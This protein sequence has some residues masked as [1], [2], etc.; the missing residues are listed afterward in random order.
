MERDII[1]YLLDQ[2]NEP[3][4]IAD[5]KKIL[6]ANTAFLELINNADIVGKEITVLFKDGNFLIEMQEERI[7]LEGEMLQDI[8][9]TE[10]IFT[11]KK[12]TIKNVNQAHYIITL[13]RGIHNRISAE[14]ADFADH[15]PVMLVQIDQNGKILFA[16][17]T[18]EE[19]LSIHADLSGDRL[20][21]FIIAEDQQRFLQFLSHNEETFDDFP[22]L[23][24]V[25]K[26]G[27]TLWMGFS[28]N[29]K[30]VDQSG[31]HIISLILMNSKIIQKEETERQKDE[32][33][34][35]NEEILAQNLE[36]E[37]SLSKNEVLVKKLMESE[38]KYR[39]LFENMMNGFALQEIITD[40]KGKPVNFRY[41]DAN[42]AFER[43][44]TMPVP[45]IIGKTIKEVL[46]DVEE[47]WI[48]VYGKVG[49]TQKPIRYENFAAA[50]N[51]YFDVWA[52]SPSKGQCAIIFNDITE[53]KNREQALLQS[54]RTYK[55]I[56]ELISD[57]IYQGEVRSDRKYKVHWIMGAV[58]NI[59]GYSIE[60]LKDHELGFSRIVHPDDLEY[61]LHNYH[62]KMLQLEEVVMEYR[63]RHKDGSQRWLLDKVK[64]IQD[65]HNTDVI[66]LFGAVTDIT[67][68]KNARTDLQNIAREYKQLIET[69]PYGIN[70]TDRNGNIIIANKG[71]SEITGYAH[72]EVI[73]KNIFDFQHAKDDKTDYKKFLKDLSVSQPKPEPFF[74]KIK[75]K[76]GSLIDVQIDWDYKKD[77]NKNIVGFVN[78]LSDI[79]ERIKAE[80][81]IQ[82][83][84]QKYKR[85]V[86]NTNALI[87]EI[88]RQGNYT[89]VNPRHE[90]LLGFS[91]EELIGKPALF[92]FHPDEKETAR[93]VYK[94]VWE[95][96]EMHTHFWKLRDKNNVYKIFE[97]KAAPY[98]D[99]KG[100]QKMVVIAYEVTERVH[101]EKQLKEMADRFKTLFY[102][103]PIGAI[104]FDIMGNVVEVNQEL[105]DILGSPSIEQTKKINV[106][107]FPLLQKFGISD[108]FVKCVN[109]GK[110]IIEKKKYVSKWG[111]ESLLRYHL[112]PI[113]DEENAVV[114]IQALV[115]DFTELDNKEKELSKREK[116]YRMLVNEMQEGLLV[117]DNDDRILFV[118]KSFCNML[119]YTEKELLGKISYK[120]LLD[121][122]DHNL[123]L[124][125]NKMRNQHKA[126]QYELTM[127]S[128]SGKPILMFLNASAI[129]N[130]KD[131]VTGSMATCVDITKI[132]EQQKALEES[133]KKY[134]NIFEN[135]KIGIF[136]SHSDGALLNLNNK[137]MEILG[138]K[139]RKESL[140]FFSDMTKLYADETKR[141]ELIQQLR[142]EGNVENFEFLARKKTGESIWISINASISQ[143]DSEQ[144][145]ILDGFAEDITHKK[146]IIE[147]QKETEIAKRS[148][149]IKEQ[150]LAN[151]SHEIRTPLTGITGMIDFLYQTELTQKQNEYLGLIKE[152]SDILINLINDILDISKIEAG[153][154]IMYDKVFNLKASLSGVK[155]MFAMRVAQKDLYL[156]M[157][158]DEKLPEWIKLDENRLKQVLINLLSNAIKFTHKGGIEIIVDLAEQLS[159]EKIKIKISVK[160]SGIGISDKD[161]ALLFQKFSQVD[162]SLTRNF[163]GSGLGLSICKELV[164]LM[165]GTIGVNSEIGSGST[166]WFSFIT[167]KIIDDPEKKQQ[168]KKIFEARKLNYEILLVE[169][170]LVN[171]KVIKMMLM[172]MGCK[173]DIALN[174]Q[175][176]LDQ[177]EIKSYDLILMDIMMP[178]MD[179]MT[180]TTKIKQKKEITAPVVGLSANAM[181]G[182]AEKYIK[183]GM[184][185]YLVKP[186][187]FEKLYEMIAKWLLGDE[188]N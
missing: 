72:E 84:Q 109:Q 14:F 122:K 24:L 19:M 118:N 101:A 80:Q 139:S 74:G 119:G 106:L 96:G 85:I 186:V 93:Q 23:R 104:I 184:D 61:I 87:C 47:K 64:P 52:F 108:D 16:T 129:S 65:P 126:E 91:Q 4:I 154:M 69:I 56:S 134:R 148:A 152:S 41:L 172:N 90:E 164:R 115:E 75:H 77:E 33:Q 111:K 68:E 162:T 123:I 183:A 50:L 105:A 88:D 171:Q 168:R 3:T 103:A 173:V 6:S 150:F 131:E 120:L 82:L 132:R 102:N 32:I 63:I 1:S 44:T 53:R 78:V 36:L 62:Y 8:L 114:M 179:G 18:L 159:D 128:K 143:Q 177:L 180:A 145:F 49:L 7:Q 83:S 116:Q 58:E 137:M 34:A 140:E 174:G 76:N 9:Y 117:V 2:H 30:E 38:K 48:E 156:N 98:R 95:K 175:D 185:D 112:A 155:N 27:K 99:D 42:E 187:T 60:E 35:Q 10:R 97:I 20:I 161:Q 5:T 133:E 158:W 29:T 157:K 151:M 66:Q 144:T 43:Q 138:C 142:K 51:K 11:F 141:A 55:L 167:K 79:T 178:V 127:Y 46:P 67:K 170:K 153:K 26:K 188:A 176:A 59:T 124:E 163:E 70:E 45:G 147:Y 146:Q 22:V 28:K 86:S 182:D 165:G 166:F 37:N 12:A 130:E 169:D 17:K 113:F 107:T 135:A 57:Y 40:E 160:D 149:V 100:A 94:E 110:K 89:Y 54:E 31:N 21:D 81:A 71:F 92:L 15:L 136:Q 181:E 39:L 73:G 121:Q 13:N 125:K 25:D